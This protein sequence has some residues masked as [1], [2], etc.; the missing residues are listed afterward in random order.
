MRCQAI[1]LHRFEPADTH[2]LGQSAGIAAVRFV[3]SYRQDRLRMPSVETDDRKAPRPT[4]RGSA[5][6]MSVRSRG[7]RAR[8]WVR[9]CVSDGLI[10]VGSDA[11]LPSKT[12][13]PF[14]FRMQ[15]LVSISETSSSTKV[16]MVAP[17]GK[18]P[19]YTL[20]SS[21]R[22]AAINPCSGIIRLA[23]AGPA[24]ESRCHFPLFMR[25]SKRIVS[26]YDFCGK[27]NFPSR[28]V[29]GVRL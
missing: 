8:R 3:G 21:R 11:T 28:S 12:S 14:W 25:L 4:M 13:A 1:D 10:A 18:R 2:H 6:P 5:R 23:I 7:R 15:T 22:A 24:G 29:R 19:R 17:L 9:A 27:F 26:H 20:P 16:S